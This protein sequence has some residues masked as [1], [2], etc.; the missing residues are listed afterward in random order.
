M[1]KNAARWLTGG[2]VE[3]LEKEFR[4]IYY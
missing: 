2:K 1:L 4:E 3:Q